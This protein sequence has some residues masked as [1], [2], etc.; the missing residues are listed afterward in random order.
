[1]FKLLVNADKLPFEVVGITSM[2]NHNVLPE[3]FIEID[4]DKFVS[5]L[6]SYTPEAQ[7]FRQICTLPG[8]KQICN[9]TIYWYR[10]GG[11]VWVHPTSW[12]CDYN[13]KPINGV[14]PHSLRFSG[15]R[16][17]YLGCQHKNYKETTIGRCQHRYACQDCPHVWE[18]DSSD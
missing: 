4:R 17:F 10:D 15:E 1:M 5:R 3:P 8:E 11:Y 9:V 16:Y 6:Q 7:E 14:V 2:G 18:V 12:M 13:R